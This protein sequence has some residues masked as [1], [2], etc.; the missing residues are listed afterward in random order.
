MKTIIKTI[1]AIAAV[2][3]LASC[4]NFNGDSQTQTQAFATGGAIS[5]QLPANAPISRSVSSGGALGGSISKFKVVV[6]NLAAKINT[7]QYANPG[8]MV[9]IDSLLPGSW[10]VA[11]FGYQN[12]A[13]GSDLELCYYGN[14]RNTQVIAGLTSYA[15]VALYDISNNMPGFEFNGLEPSNVPDLAYAYMTW[16]CAELG[17]SGE[18]F[19]ACSFTSDMTTLKP[20]VPV[21][22]EPGYTYQAKITFYNFGQFTAKYT[23]TVEGVVPAAGGL[24]EGR[25]N[26]LDKSFTLNGNLNYQYVIG[27]S[28]ADYV[29]GQVAD[30]GFD[31]GG[32]TIQCADASY[33][34]VNTDACGGS[35]PYIASYGAYSCILTPLV[36]HPAIVPTVSVPDQTVQ[37]GQTITV[38]VALNPPAPKE[39]PMLTTA[40]AVNGFSRYIVDSDNSDSDTWTHALSCNDPNANKVEFNNNDKT[41]TGKAAGTNNFT[42]TVTVTA[43]S[44][45]ETP[46]TSP[47]TANFTATCVE[48]TQPSGGGGINYPPDPNWFSF[49]STPEV[50]PEGTQGAAEVIYNNVSNGT[51]LLYPAPTPR[52]VK[53]GNYPRTHKAAS[54]NIDES[55][56]QTMGNF[57]YYKGDDNNWYAKFQVKKNS[58]TTYYNNGTDTIEATSNY[59]YFKLEPITWRV[60]TT[61]YKGTGKALLVT[62][63]ALPG[64]FDYDT[65]PGHKA[66]AFVYNSDYS[67]PNRTIGGKTIY[68]NN[69]QYSNARA[70]LNG[71]DGS[72]YDQQDWTNAGF[73]N[74]AFTEAGRMKIAETD[75]DNS[76][77]SCYQTFE[78][79]GTTYN[80]YLSDNTTDKV[81]ILSANEITNPLYGFYEPSNQYNSRCYIPTDLAL[82]SNAQVTYNPTTIAC[83]YCYLRSPY[84]SDT[85][86]QSCGQDGAIGS[87]A[88]SVYD[89]YSNYYAPAICVD[90]SSAVG[91]QIGKVGEGNAAADSH[92]LLPGKFTV[93]ASGKQVKFSQSNLWKNIS[94]STEYHFV[95]Q[96]Y[97][98][99]QRNKDRE[100][101]GYFKYN[102]DLFEYMDQTSISNIS[103][104][105]S[106]ITNWRLLTA[107]E[108]QYLFEGRTNAASKFG[109]ARINNFNYTGGK[110]EYM[111]GFI[112]LP[113]SWTAPAGISFTPGWM[114]A[115][116][117]F[118]TDVNNTYD[119][120]DW[121]KMEEAGAVFLPAGGYLYTQG[122]TIDYYCSQKYGGRYWNASDSDPHVASIDG[123]GLTPNYTNLSPYY[124]IKYA[125]IRLV[126]DSN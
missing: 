125:S 126:V 40:N 98:Y 44:Y 66:F 84:T 33:K 86:L 89:D 91:A 14:A 97:Y 99:S 2:F 63:E 92:G 32:D 37:K 36:H 119:S 49:Q 5:I 8:S 21:F 122:S 101:T 104:A 41:L 57:T 4:D 35:V 15:N 56:S 93:N 24:V 95:S 6:R 54:V 17:Q 73:I 67:T 47:A 13:Q 38:S 109:V 59:A 70:W 114:A 20:P 123:D 110:S 74:S 48:T 23:G 7:E 90:L 62:D 83:C 3:A 100:S 69:Y 85:G 116:T 71:L 88:A 46:A 9:T 103:I 106:D 28:F 94:T 68:K 12:A 52:Y 27:E 81:F 115:G 79:A 82:A 26:A 105:E 78:V 19:Y 31:L 96:Q 120:W 77:Q 18:E 64:Y 39:W 61:N 102:H 10:D 29:Y 111:T 34:A 50:L 22:M 107:D 80:N 113:D 112:L 76:A 75:V 43:G 124:P 42:W 45:G 121:K 55:V 25:A 51:R 11:I 30:Q 118:P 117:N 65:S 53:F 16:S 108:W 72:G 1:A 87:G 60:L 58:G